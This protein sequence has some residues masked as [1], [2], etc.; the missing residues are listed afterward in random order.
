MRITSISS[1]VISPQ[2]GDGQLQPAAPDDGHPY[3]A[4]V[5]HQLIVLPESGLSKRVERGLLQ[6]VQVTAAAVRHMALDANLHR[7]GD[8]DIQQL[9]FDDLGHAVAVSLPF[10]ADVRTPAIVSVIAVITRY[11]GNVILYS[12]TLSPSPLSAR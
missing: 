4:V 3:N 11:Y 6:V 9:V 1:D 8:A 12:L 5:V 10:R 7:A 2:F